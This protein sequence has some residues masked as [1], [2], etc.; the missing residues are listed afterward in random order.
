MDSDGFSYRIQTN[1]ECRGCKSGSQAV[2]AKLHSQKGNSPDHHLRSLNQ[3][4]CVRKCLGFD[5]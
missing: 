4:K 5:R 1:S 2:G 3:T